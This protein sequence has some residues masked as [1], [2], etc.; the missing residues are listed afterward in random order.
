MISLENEWLKIGTGWFHGEYFFA[1]L[2]DF[3]FQSYSPYNN[4][5]V[6][7][8][9]DLLTSKLLFGHDILKGVNLGFRVE[10][11]YDLQRKSNDF[12][13]GLNVCVNAEVFGK[14]TKR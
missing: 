11:Y 10:S 14:K 2:G 7:E 3:L 6:G 12:S 9:R 4:W 13:Y 5:Y 8:K 1:P